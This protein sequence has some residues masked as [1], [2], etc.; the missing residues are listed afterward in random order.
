[1]YVCQLCM[2]AKTITST[3]CVEAQRREITLICLQWLVPVSPKPRLS[4]LIEFI[5]LSNHPHK[6]RLS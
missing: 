4:L 2:Y 1:M 3:L 5:L 6:D